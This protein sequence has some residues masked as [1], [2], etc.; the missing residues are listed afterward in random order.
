MIVVFWFWKLVQ[1][2]PIRPYKKR[3]LANIPG[4]YREGK[5][6]ES[7]ASFK[8][9]PKKRLRT[10][11]KVAFEN[12]AGTQISQSF[13]FID[14]KPMENRYLKDNRISLVLTDHP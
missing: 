11:I 4:V 13:I 3:Q 9:S 2:D 10:K 7:N 8:S 6:I 1:I 12:L 14:S 5:I